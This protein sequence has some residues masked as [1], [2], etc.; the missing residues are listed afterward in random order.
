MHLARAGWLRWRDSCCPSRRPGRARGRWRSGCRFT[1]GAG[2][3]LTEAGT[4]KR[5]AVY[6]VT[7]PAAVPGIAALGPDPLDPAFTAGR[8][9]GHPGR[10][11]DPDQGRAAGSE[12]H[13]RNRQRL[14]RRGP[15]RRPDVAVPAGLQPS[16]E[17]VA[18]LH[19]VIV[20]TLREAI[21]RS[22]GPGRRGPEGGEEGRAAGARQDRPALPGL[23]RHRARGLVR[24]LGAAVLP[25]L[26]DRRQAAG[27]PPDVPAAAVSR[28]V[29]A[30]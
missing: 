27:R 23:R 22:A 24:R 10:P 20:G 26:P 13:R 16:S 7:D 2:F 12:D 30:G 19:E 21:A 11:P 29:P 5:L 15:A 8:L 14:L 25:H 1:D 18:G 4:R 28:Y 3:D 6:L 9:A 17:E